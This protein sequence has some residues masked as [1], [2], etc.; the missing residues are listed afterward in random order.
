MVA[1]GGLLRHRRAAHHLV[2]C[3]YSKFV[4]RCL[5]DGGEVFPVVGGV[6]VENSPARYADRRA[7]SHRV[8]G[9]GIDGRWGDPLHLYLRD[10]ANTTICVI[11]DA[12]DGS[13]E[14]QLALQQVAVVECTCADGDEVRRQFRFFQSHA[15]AKSAVTYGIYSTKVD[16]L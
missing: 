4:R 5:H 6:V 10:D 15:A 14:C 13:R 2:V 1:A 3:G 9:V 12:G 7:A 8:E 16:I 11:P